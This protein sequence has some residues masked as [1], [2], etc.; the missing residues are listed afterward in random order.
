MFLRVRPDS[1]FTVFLE[2]TQA[3]K[4]SFVIYF[5]VFSDMPAHP[6]AWSIVTVFSDMPAHP[7]SVF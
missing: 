5:T 6:D 2:G 4:P 3:G 7:D 1:H